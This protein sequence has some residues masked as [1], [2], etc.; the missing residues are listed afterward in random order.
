MQPK[1]NRKSYSIRD[2]EP[3]AAGFYEV[4]TKEQTM[5][6]PQYSKRLRYWDGKEWLLVLKD[7]LQPGERS[8]PLN[9][10]PFNYFFRPLRKKKPK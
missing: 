10:N 5:V 2:F 9:E 7:T 1:S 3:V 4:K 6:P 8:I